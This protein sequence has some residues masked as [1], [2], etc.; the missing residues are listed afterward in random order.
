MSAMTRAVLTGVAALLILKALWRAASPAMG[1]EYALLTTLMIAVYLVLGEYVGLRAEGLRP[2]I[3][4]GGAVGL[5]EAAIDWPIWAAIGPGAPDP[6]ATAGAI[7]WIV[8]F[9]TLPGAGIAAIGAWAG[10]RL[11]ARAAG[12]PQ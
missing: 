7:A 2:P 6:G 1:F 3:I 9:P 12:R 5:V 11:R 8:L 4:A 10:R